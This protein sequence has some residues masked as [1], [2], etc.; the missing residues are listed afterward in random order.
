M[1]QQPFSIGQ[2]VLI[3]PL[4]LTGQIT[5]MFFGMYGVP[6]CY[7]QYV[8]TRR[9]LVSRFFTADLLKHVAES[10]D[11]PMNNVTPMERKK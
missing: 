9:E 5:G 6:Q 3:K 7:V 10:Q 2:N 11:N 4:G 8:N 1:E